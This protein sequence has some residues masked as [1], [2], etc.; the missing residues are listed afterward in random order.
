MIPEA[1]W[2]TYGLDSVG[3][4]QR[5]LDASMGTIERLTGLRFAITPHTGR[6]C[7]VE[8]GG[9]VVRLPGC[10]VRSVEAIHYSESGTW[11]SLELLEPER[12]R[13]GSD[14][15]L[16]V[17]SNIVELNGAFRDVR[18]DYTTGLQFDELPADIVEAIANMAKSMERVDKQP[19]KGFK[20]E[21]IGNYTYT[22]PNAKDQTVD[23]MMFGEHAVFE[24]FAASVCLRV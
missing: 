19:I 4:P 17:R 11:G 18:A 16:H 24:R 13:R 14:S 22:L 23:G 9:R 15:P 12:W 7:R 1:D 10:L 3:E 2:S 8:P 20:S 6:I 5:R 21:R